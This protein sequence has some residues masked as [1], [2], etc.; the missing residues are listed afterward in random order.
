M[1]VRIELSDNPPLAMPNPPDKTMTSRPD[2]DMYP[3]YSDDYNTDMK[4]WV[5]QNKS[6]RY[7][8]CRCVGDECNAVKCP[9][10]NVSLI[11]PAF[12]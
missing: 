10:K 9:A 3:P 12:Y 6:C 2:P 5:A 1:H 8:N 4:K 11:L 7:P